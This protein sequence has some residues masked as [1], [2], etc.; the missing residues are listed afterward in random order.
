MIL[1]TILCNRVHK[2]NSFSQI[3][4]RI[5]NDRVVFAI[6][7]DK[8]LCFIGTLKRAAPYESIIDEKTL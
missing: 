4:A 5:Y 7:E 1:G 2:S 3:K 6:T 8:K